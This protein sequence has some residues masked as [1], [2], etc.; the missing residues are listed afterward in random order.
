MLLCL[1]GAKLGTW[2]HHHLARLTAPFETPS[3][4]ESLL[5]ASEAELDGE[6]VHTAKPPHSPHWKQ[7]GYVLIPTVFDLLAT[8][9][10]SVGLLYVTVSIYQMM[11]GTEVVFAALFSIVFLRRKLN[12][13][14]YAGIFLVLVGITV[15]G[16]AGA[17][18]GQGPPENEASSGAS[19]I[20][21]GML[22]IVAAEAVQAAQVVA[23]DHFMSS[24]SLDPVTIVGF[25][26]LLGTALLAGIVMPIMQNVS[27]PEGQGFH[28]DSLE[29]LHMLAHSR[30]LLIGFVTYIAVIAIYNVA[31]MMVTEEMGAVTRT[32]LETLRTLFVWILD[33]LLFYAAPMGKGKLG[34]PWTAYSWL[35]AGGFLV[36]VLGTLLYGRGEEV[37]EAELKRFAKRRARERWAKIRGSLTELTAAA[38]ADGKLLPEERMP[39]R[40][41]RIAGPARIRTAFLPVLFAHRVQG[42]ARPRWGSVA[43]SQ[44]LDDHHLGLGEPARTSS[45]RASMEHLLD[46]EGARTHPHPQPH[47]S[48]AP[49]V[50]RSRD[51]SP[52]GYRH[53]P[54]P[55]PPPRHPHNLAEVVEEAV[56]ASSSGAAA[57]AN[58]GAPATGRD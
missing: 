35:Q 23:E 24:L 42:L 40:P 4:E 55:R 45:R 5:S 7:L 29:S 25:E 48:P 28:E 49:G 44:H 38:A 53:P 51:A 22:L 12:Y 47:A 54:P 27:G 1:P 57:H 56:G 19:Q 9:L 15:V 52:A 11:R 41:P 2:L 37:Q 3:E 46:L 8:I 14:H 6:D 32:V 10:M 13:Q 21:L 36:L 17:Q 20:I 16:V 34:E 26:G 43:T 58:G 30:P 18:S 39:M 50:R 31:G 33:L